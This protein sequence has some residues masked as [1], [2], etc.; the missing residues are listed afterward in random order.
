MHIVNF[1]QEFHE[2]FKNMA[3]SKHT[4][5][6]RKLSEIHLK[7]VIVLFQRQLLNL[8]VQQTVDLIISSSRFETLTP[9]ALLE[10]KHITGCHHPAE[11]DLWI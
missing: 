3:N 7:P 1:I 11:V 2:N 4:S 8:D 5:Q 9:Q 10:E 6:H